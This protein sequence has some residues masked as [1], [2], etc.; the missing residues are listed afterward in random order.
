VEV[1][2]DQAVVDGRK[3]PQLKK[4]GR[5]ASTDKNAA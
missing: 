1:I 2:I 5:G 3:K 4:L